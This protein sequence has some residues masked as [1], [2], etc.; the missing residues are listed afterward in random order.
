MRRTTWMKSALRYQVPVLQTIQPRT[1]LP[2]ITAPVH[3]NGYSQ[4]GS[5][6]AT[7]ANAL[8]FKLLVQLRGD[9]VTN[10]IGLSLANSA[11]GSTIAGL[12]LTV[13]LAALS[14]CSALAR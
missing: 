3:I 14:K 12:S 9:S 8:D 4:P 6:P 7:A 10:G 2:T 1:A 5:Q 13:G 11:S